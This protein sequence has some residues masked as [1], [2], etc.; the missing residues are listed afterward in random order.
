MNVSISSI[1]TALHTNLSAVSEIKQV[2]RGRTSSLSSF[3]AIRHYFVGAS[4]TDYTNQENYR[5]YTF[6]IEIVCPL[7]I[8][9]QT[10]TNIEDTIQDAVDAVMDKLND[11]WEMAQIN[12]SN[13]E[14]ITVSTVG[15]E[16]GTELIAVIVWKART[17]IEWD[18]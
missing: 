15:D 9:S 13:I 12:Q 18:Q 4:D 1:R 5:T 14:S 8:E 11:K 7:T 6:N 17:L 10:K 3:P 2:V 16:R